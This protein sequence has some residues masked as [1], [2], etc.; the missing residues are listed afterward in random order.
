M[1]LPAH[2]QRQRHTWSLINQFL[3]TSGKIDGYTYNIFRGK[4]LGN[5]RN[6]GKL[7]N[8]AKYRKWKKY[9]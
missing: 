7:G 9:G 8:A 4:N 1:A 2:Q 6:M 5:M 3:C